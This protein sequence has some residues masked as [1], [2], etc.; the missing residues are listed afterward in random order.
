MSKLLLWIKYLFTE[1]TWDAGWSI[2]SQKVYC[3][4][5]ATRPLKP[6]LKEVYGS[7]CKM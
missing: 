1:Y 7:L 3:K 5:G 2:E 6:H 4:C